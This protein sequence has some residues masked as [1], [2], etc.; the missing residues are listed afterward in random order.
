MGPQNPSI[1]NKRPSS[2]LLSCN[3]YNSCFHSFSICIPS[4]G[5]SQRSSSPLPLCHLHSETLAT[6]T[7]DPCQMKAP[8]IATIAV[9][10]L[11]SPQTSQPQFSQPST[12]HQALTTS[13]SR[14]SSQQNGQSSPSTNR[15]SR[16]STLQASHP[17]AFPILPTTAS[18]KSETRKQDTCASSKTPSPTHPSS[19]APANMT[20]ASGT[21]QWLFS[22]CKF[23]SRSP[24]WRS[25]PDSYNRPH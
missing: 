17:S 23:S 22:A 10:T 14:I 13:F 4:F 9:L 6:Q 16:P 1:S 18:K 12:A 2:E 3:H 25:Q 19:R 20:S 24:A 7:S 8:T 5:S 11:H 21:M 15:V